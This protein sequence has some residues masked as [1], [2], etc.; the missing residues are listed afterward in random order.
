MS[1]FKVVY[2]VVK[3][4]PEGKVTTYGQVAKMVNSVSSGKRISPVFIGWALHGNR[5]LKVPCHRVVNKK[6]RLAPNFAFD[7]H[8]EQRRR[9]KAEKVTFDDDMHVNLDVHLWEPSL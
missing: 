5:D 6:G 2:E 1:K 9:L 8:E 7:G 3:K 4:I